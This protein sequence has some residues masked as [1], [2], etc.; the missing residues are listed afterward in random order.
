MPVSKSTIACHVAIDEAT[1]D[2]DL[3]NDFRNNLS[4]IKK[5]FREKY[6]D[7][8]T[9]PQEVKDILQMRTWNVDIDAVEKIHYARQLLVDKSVKISDLRDPT[10][11]RQV[12]TKEDAFHQ[13]EPGSERNQKFVSVDDGGRQE[14]VI[15]KT[16][17]GAD[18]WE[19]LTDD[20]GPKDVGT[21]NYFGNAQSNKKH[22][23][24]DVATWK[25]FGN[26]KKDTTS[27]HERTQ[28]ICDA[29]RDRFEDDLDTPDDALDKIAD[30]VNNSS[31]LVFD[32]DGDGIELSSLVGSTVGWD[33]D[34]DGFREQT[35]W[36]DADDGLLAIDLNGNGIIDD[37]GELFGSATQDG[38]SILASY[39]SNDDGTMTDADADFARLLIWRDL[40]QD[41]YSDVGE[42]FTLA[43][44][45]IVAIDLDA[46]TVNQ[47]N[48]GHD[49]TH[50]STYTVTIGG[51]DVSRSV[52]DVW[53]NYNDVNS[54]YIPDFEWDLSTI[55][56]P[57]LRGY[58]QM[59]D[60]RFAA[61]SGHSA[62]A[63][64]LPLVQA[65]EDAT[66]VDLVS[67]SARIT[68]DFR[69]VLFAWAEVSNVDPT[70]R[71]PY[72]DARELH[73]LEAFSAEPY[74][75]RGWSPNPFV[76]AAEDLKE[77]FQI[78]YDT[79]FARFFA[80]T[81]GH[82]VFSIHALEQTHRLPVGCASA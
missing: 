12:G 5:Q 19:I 59:A 13:F 30:G 50:F 52:V 70:S 44:L 27:E 8:T 58:G 63:G 66:L 18:D 24:L 3:V 23:E 4:Q 77:A 16:G 15:R 36:V 69:D 51:A 74:F 72:I 65:L 42:L 32:L 73:F 48:A 75:Q 14:F 62:S 9:R 81:I 53:F 41:G 79:Y 25:R 28:M 35:G 61:M 76:Y 7:P 34:K 20:T 33:I 11:F 46:N 2:N 64:L 43:D 38:F 68:E 45:S 80:Q 17:P 22:L 60:L 10:K 54:V 40:N 67:D 71:G 47:I 1:M 29:L 56:L 6:S 57:Q 82:E 21:Y 37:H 31:P 26:S 49:V 78:L 55:F 39:D